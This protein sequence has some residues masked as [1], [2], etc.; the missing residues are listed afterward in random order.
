MYSSGVK[1]VILDEADAMT[2]DA[3]AALRRGK[4]PLSLATLQSADNTHIPDN[5]SVIQQSSR[6]TH[7]TRA[8]VLYVTMSTRSCLLFSRDAPSK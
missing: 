3:Q 4:Q 8:S 6:S 1:L 5:T 2:S 7:R